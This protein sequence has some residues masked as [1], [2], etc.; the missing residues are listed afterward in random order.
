KYLGLPA[1][2]TPASILFFK[3]F[4]YLGSYP[5]STTIGPV[6]LSFNAL[7]TALA[8]VC[9]KFKDLSDAEVDQLIFESFAI[10]HAIPQP[11]SRLSVPPEIV[12]VELLKGENSVIPIAIAD[13]I[14][15]AMGDEMQRASRGFTLAD[16][17][18][19]FEDEDEEFGDAAQT[20][21]RRGSE[22][23]DEEA[24]AKVLARDFAE[25]MA[26]FFW[27]IKVELGVEEAEEAE[28]KGHHGGY[29]EDKVAKLKERWESPEWLD[30]ERRVA[31]DIAKVVC[32]A[33]DRL[34]AN[35]PT[36]A[37]LALPIDL[38]EFDDQT[39]SL[40]WGAFAAWKPR[41]APNLFT[42][43]KSYFYT[44]FVLKPTALLSTDP[45]SPIALAFTPSSPAHPP[46]TTDLILDEDPPPRADVTDILE[47]VHI[48]LLSWLLPLSVTHQK[49]WNRLYS[50]SVDGFSMNRFERHV[51]KYPG[52]TL[53]LLQVE[54]RGGE[55]PAGVYTSSPVTESLSGNFGPSS[56]PPS[57]PLKRASSH[58]PSAH[59]EDTQTM[60]LGAY[61]PD[62]WRS[63]R[64]AWGSTDCLVFELSPALESY[65]PTS[66]NSQHVYYNSAFGIGFG[67]WSPLS[68]PT[69][70]SPGTSP[71]SPTSRNRLSLHT[72]NSASAFVLTLSNTLQTGTYAN[73]VFPPLPTLKPS[74]T[75]GNFR[76]AFEIIEIE[77]F[78][79]GG[80]GAKD[81]QRK[82]WEFELKEA[83]RRATVHIRKD[84]LQGDKEI[85][86]LAGI[87]DEEKR[88]DR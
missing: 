18:I 50:G 3:S 83:T 63:S 56:R 84:R 65:P 16:M 85:L 64:S 74:A 88:H 2:L 70:S 23:E 14:A 5:N 81:T 32:V 58:S 71:S 1:H 38:A 34:R 57:Y 4:S 10:V 36:N 8:L 47:P 78:G 13:A 30:H 44:H 45:A 77:V 6:P 28:G 15:D 40:S 53:L 43:C 41:N 39:A 12:A 66:R 60:I 33:D 86:K 69:P 54:A 72:A 19:S 59:D 37:A 52:P 46:P 17:G 26:A 42:T 80:E 48:A 9:R 62:H 49:R 22:R 24:G 7:L 67:G 68:M 25:L 76:Y 73:E 75:R 31:R 11:I 27:M 20:A 55:L 29:E 51:F 87:I 21:S 82:E 35:L 79:I 61:V